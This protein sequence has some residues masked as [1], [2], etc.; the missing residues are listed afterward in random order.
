MLAKFYEDPAQ[1][2][3]L[4]IRRARRRLAKVHYAA[5]KI[6]LQEGRPREARRYLQRALHYRPGYAKAWPFYAFA[7]LRG[8]L[9]AD[10]PS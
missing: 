7:A 6:L 1:R 5:G 10:R 3:M 4:D 2:Q 8:L 9:G